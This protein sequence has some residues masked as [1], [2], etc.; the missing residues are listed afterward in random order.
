[1]EQIVTKGYS[2]KPGDGVQD[3]GLERMARLSWL[4]AQVQVTRGEEKEEDKSWV[5]EER[6]A[7]VRVCAH[8]HARTGSQEP[9][10]VCYVEQ[11]NFTT[12]GH[13]SRA[14]ENLQDRG[15]AGNARLSWLRVLPPPPTPPI[16]ERGAPSSLPARSCARGAL[17]ARRSL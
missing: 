3:C 13:P 14:L 11:V 5:V 4:R 16:E 17:R 6:L 8:I 9:Q 1:M 7:R 15:L 12:Q 2:I 10:G